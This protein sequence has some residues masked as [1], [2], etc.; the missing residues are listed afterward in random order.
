M[1]RL[2][3][4]WQKKVIEQAIKSRRVLLLNGARQ[5]GKTTLVKQ[6]ISKNTTYLTLDDQGLK[7]SAELDPQSFVQHDKRMMIIDEVQRVPSLL[8]A[9]KKTV[10]ED[11]R[12]G[13]YLLTGSA[14]IQSLPTTQESLAGRIRKIHLRT[15]SYGEISGKVP[16]FFDYAF[17]QAFDYKS[18]MYSRDDLLNSAF[19]G[20][21]PE[22]LK[23]SPRQRKLWYGDYIEAL[24]ERDLQ[25]IARI[26]RKESMYGLVQV[27]AAWSSKL[28]DLSAIGAG[29]AIKRPTL[30]TYVNAL[31]ALYLVDRVRAWTKTDYGRVG[32]QKKL[33][34]VDCG[35][36]ASILDWG[37][38]QVKF[39]AD[40][41]GKLME[42]FIFNELAAQI[43]ASNGEYKLFHYRDYE[44][45]EIDFL[46]ERDDSSLI[47]V[48]VKASSTAQSSFFKHLR[49]FQENLA[50]NRSFVGIVLY[51]GEHALSSGKNLGA[52]PIGRLWPYQ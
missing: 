5:C 14:N 13:Q 7:R 9:I 17:K 38:D 33:F 46:V 2:Y 47:G 41:S 50:K 31:E 40:R 37:V 35:L 34:M 20:G 24:I 18:D 10:D 4:R 39:D 29:L 51:T 36:M 12:P 11:T 16:K 8:L 6:L 22:A 1:D 30:E 21:F 25:D 49:W 26:Q 48:E 32:K 44:G 15:L 52:V 43:G 27:L 28:I 42:T 23:L 45:R 19:R 3:A